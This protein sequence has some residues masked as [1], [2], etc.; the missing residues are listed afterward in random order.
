MKQHIKRV[1]WK[2]GVEQ[3]F[4]SELSAIQ[5]IDPEWIH[6]TDGLFHPDYRPQKWV[7]LRYSH[8]PE[9]AKELS[10]C[11][12]RDVDRMGLPLH[13]GEEDIGRPRYLLR[14]AIRRDRTYQRSVE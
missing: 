13:T 14:S 11:E 1:N 6:G 2:D 4:G 5:E 9:Q 10:C 8:Q 12:A 7:T 3:Y